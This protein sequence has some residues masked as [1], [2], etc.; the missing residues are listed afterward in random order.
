[1]FFQV[2]LFAQVLNLSIFW[3]LIDSQLNQIDHAISKELDKIEN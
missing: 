2:A 3:K 1:M